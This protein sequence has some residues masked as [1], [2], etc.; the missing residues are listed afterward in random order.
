MSIVQE[1]ASKV[2]NRLREAKR[3]LI[4]THL[5]P[6]GDALGS[7]LAMQRVLTSVGIEA[8]VVCHHAAPRNLRFLPQVEN[9]SPVPRM[10]G[11]DLG[12]VLDLDSLDRLGSTRPY[13]EACPF[14][15]VV[16]HHVP[17]DQPG[18]LRLVDTTASATAAILTEFL[19]EVG[20]DI[21]ASTALCLLTGIVTDTGSFRFRNSDARSLHLA[22]ALLERGADIN[23]VSDE[24]FGRKPLA[25]T[26]LLGHVLEHMVLEADERICWA[27]LSRADFDAC[28]ARDEDTE[29]FVNELLAIES[30]EIAALFRESKAGVARV[31]LRSRQGYDVAQVAQQFGGGGHRNAAG[32]NLEG[33]LKGKIAD[34]VAALNQCLASSP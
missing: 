13:L 16:D 15:I 29:G 32:L 23:L 34:V 31:S 7:A 10:E 3:V 22:A 17:M 25:A 21:D 24:I 18:D 1:N 12:L 2:W 5:N 30:V 19:L 6:D 26:R 14:M 20:A 8:E 33:D 27:F 28:G 4:G 9:L 11:H